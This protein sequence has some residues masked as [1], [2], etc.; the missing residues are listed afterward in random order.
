MR[1][2]SS[3]FLASVSKTITDPV[4]LIKIDFGSQFVYASS[5]E[6]IVYDGNNYNFLGAQI[7]SIDS[8]R[9]EFSLPNFDRAISALAL[10]GQIQGNSVTVYL[11]Y[12][13]E[14]ITRFTGLL[15]TPNIVADYNTMRFSCVSE[16]ATNSKWPF[17]RLRPPIANHLPPPGT[18]II[19][20]NVTI[21]LERDQS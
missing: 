9:V 15:D 14:T 2:L 5:R 18:I 4:F 19:I 20:G 3:T 8:T 17:D 21:T 11:H 1:T 12:D 10:A 13:G 6:A 7:I 16:Y